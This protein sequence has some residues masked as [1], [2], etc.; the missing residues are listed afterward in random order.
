MDKISEEQR[1]YNMSRIRSK[2]T[3]PEMLVRQYLHAHG[4]RYR[5]HV[6][7]L[8]GHPDLVLNKYKTVLFVHGCFW[9]MHE[10]CKYAT[11]PKSRTEWW[12]EKLLRNKSRDIE[13]TQKLEALGWN[14]ITV[15]EC[16]LKKS[17]ADATLYKLIERILV[18]G[19][20]DNK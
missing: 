2:D 17:A 20:A 14:V 8:P 5:L 19:G 18:G 7:T 1:S 9:H 11:M 10:N 16:E 15:W 6:K 13:N 4:F 3:K 12:T